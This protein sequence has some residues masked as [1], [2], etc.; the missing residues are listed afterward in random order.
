MFSSAIILALACGGDL[1]SPPAKA[2]PQAS[3]FE[4]ARMYQWLLAKRN[5]AKDKSAPAAKQ[6]KQ[7]S[8]LSDARLELRCRNAVF[9]EPQLRN[10]GMTVRVVDG[11]AYLEGAAGNRWLRLRAEQLAGTTPGVIRVEN[12]LKLVE[13]SEKKATDGEPP[14]LQTTENVQTAAKQPSGMETLV[15]RPKS[16]S[17]DDGEPTVTTYTIR[18]GNEKENALKPAVANSPGASKSGAGR[19]VRWDEMEPL[20]TAE[21]NPIP[22]PARAPVIDEP[23]DVEIKK[24]LASSPKTK[25]WTFTRNGKDVVLHGSAPPSTMLKAAQEIGTLDGV[26]TVTFEAR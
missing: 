26:A 6:P 13:A 20:P 12:H 16:L 1:D 17:A 9:N 5:G 14:L 15:S 22:R 3:R 25:G 24:L 10:S 2:T 21:G 11:V 23:V 4:F 19:L 8:N 7:E 18:R